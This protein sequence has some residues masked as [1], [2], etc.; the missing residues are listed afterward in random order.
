MNPIRY[1]ENIRNN[2]GFDAKN[3]AHSVRLLHMGIEIAK[4]GEMHVD[5][6]DID[7]EFILSIRDGKMDYDEL[8]AYLISKEKEMN[9]AMEESTIPD[10]IDIDM[11]NE[12]LLE[13]RRLQLKN[14][15]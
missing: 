10:K 11:V 9:I 7:R 5:R 4:T 8:M 14:F 12:I 1:K 15:N 2:K 13:I 6:R 3:M